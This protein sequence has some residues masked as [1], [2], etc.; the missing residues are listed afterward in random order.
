MKQL[1]LRSLDQEAPGWNPTGGGS[2]LM[3]IWRIVVQSLSLSLS[4]S[5]DLN[6]LKW[7]KTLNHLLNYC[8]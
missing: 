1:V 5:Y 4:I 2:Q 3:T 8:V 6:G 7:C